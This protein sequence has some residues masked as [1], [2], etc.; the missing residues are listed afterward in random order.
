VLP[1]DSARFAGRP[2]EMKL[3]FFGNIANNAYNF[4]NCLRRLGYDAEL[5]IEDGWF[6]AFLM[7]RPSWED[8][9]AECEG[10]E[11]GLACDRSWTAPAAVRRVAY[12]PECQAR[13]QGRFS[14]IPEVQRLY[15]EAFGQEL[16]ADRALLLAQLM[17]HWPY[18]A[19]MQPYDAIQF[20]GAS[21]AMA[22]FSPKPYVVFPTGGDVFL[23]PFEENL[24]GLIMRAAYRGAAC[25]ALCQVNYAQYLDRFAAGRTRLFAPMMADTDTYCPGEEPA[26]RARWREAVGGERYVLNVC[27][28]SWHWKGND[29]LIRGFARFHQTAGG[30]SWRLVLMQWGPDV[31]KTRRLVA[32]LGL[33]ERVVWERLSS[34]PLLRQRQRAADVVADQFV[35][36]GYGASVLESMAAGKP[37]LMAPLPDA[38]RYFPGD[39]PPFLGATQPDQIAEVLSA[40]VDGQALSRQSAESLAWVRRHHGYHAVAPTYLRAFLHALGCVGKEAL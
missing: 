39:P 15:R 29:R 40:V 17:G 19:A 3:G 18:L 26:V 16:A 10:F 21:I 12:D 14:A 36:A 32:E 11:E 24:M 2:E 1:T 34:K 4:V 37:V 8:V 25:I 30:R 20:S 23:S 5:V 28:Q 31:D 27:R 13:Y 33:Q 35:M 7:N 9:P 6:D 38:D 22:A